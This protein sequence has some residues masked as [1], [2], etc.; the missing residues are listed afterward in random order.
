MALGL[1]HP[2]APSRMGRGGCGFPWLRL[3]AHCLTSWGSARVERTRVADAGG[4]Q[5]VG[6]WVVLLDQ[7]DAVFQVAA[8]LPICST[9]PIS[10]S[11]PARQLSPRREMPFRCAREARSSGS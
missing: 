3:P 2:V 6:A 9:A 11:T 7:N 1:R 4:P 10:L 8:V 5:I